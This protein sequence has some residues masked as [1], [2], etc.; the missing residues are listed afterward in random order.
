MPSQR[1]RLDQN[2]VH[3]L[4]SSNSQGDLYL[5]N[6]I[7][8]LQ[9]RVYP[10]GTKSW[11]L[12]KK[13]KGKS[14]RILIGRFP[15]VSAEEALQ[16]A[17]EIKNRKEASRIT[18]Y[19]LWL[20]YMNEHAKPHK[21]TWQ[22][23]QAQYR[24]YLKRW[25]DR[26]LDKVTKTDIRELHASLSERPIA[27]NRTLA[28]LSRVYEF[29][30]E[31]DLATF[32]PTRGIRRYKEKSRSRFL[33]PSEVEAFADA[34]SHEEQMF[35][36]FFRLCLFTGAR[37]TNVL[38][39]Q[40]SEIDW[41][42]SAWHIPDTKN[43]EPVTVVLVPSAVEILNRRREEKTESPFVF[44]SYGRTGHL[45]E[46]KI[47]WERIRQRSGLTDLRMHDL[48]RT[49]GSWQAMAGTSL[50]VIGK[51]LGHK[52]LQSTEVY[53][54]LDL[55]PVRESVAGAVDALKRLSGEKL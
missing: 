6:L 46:P 1:L 52:S 15:Q 50:P 45:R 5:D 26:P 27:A 9:L 55:S 10:T 37:K 54:R 8:G 11:F 30:I 48:R 4:Q 41:K 39:M 20:R 19:H 35:Q 49:M 29:A 42:H 2:T 17:I 43:G 18:F 3:N 44:P 24:R 36:D 33:Q 47:A 34:L 23:D 40:W 31:V 28:L 32:N 13:E 25:A 12:R 14:L 38:Q 53:A 51:S 21:K 7:T 16:R 22:E